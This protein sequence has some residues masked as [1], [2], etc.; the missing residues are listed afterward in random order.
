MLMS[1][2]RERNVRETIR[3]KLI[4]HLMRNDAQQRLLKEKPEDRHNSV[5]EID[6]IEK[7]NFRPP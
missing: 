1:R 3:Q 7:E 4:A 2:Q 6:R 5:C